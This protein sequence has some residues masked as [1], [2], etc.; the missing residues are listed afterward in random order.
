MPSI[1]EFC[2]NPSWPGP[3][4]S[5][6]CCPHT[7]QHGPPLSQSGI[8]T[9]GAAHLSTGTVLYYEAQESG[10]NSFVAS[11]RPVWVKSNKA[12]WRYMKTHER[13]RGGACFGSTSRQSMTSTRPRPQC[14]RS[15]RD[16]DGLP[17]LGLSSPSAAAALPAGPARHTCTSQR[18]F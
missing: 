7:R 18:R 16:E 4:Q 11:T 17:R 9:F 8:S 14:K 10:Q 1:G 13:N 2:W 15:V 5:R 12:I 3:G 6:K